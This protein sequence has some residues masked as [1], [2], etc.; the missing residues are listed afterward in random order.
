MRKWPPPHWDVLERGAHVRVVDEEGWVAATLPVEHRDAAEA[1]A[2]ALNAL[3]AWMLH[4]GDNGPLRP[5]HQLTR[6]VW[7]RVRRRRTHE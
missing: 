6:E 5:A 7:E 2:A 1:L 4:Y 3:E